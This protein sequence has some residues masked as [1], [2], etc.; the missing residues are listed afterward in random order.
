MVKCWNTLK[1]ESLIGESTM[2]NTMG[3][4]QVKITWEWLAGFYDGEGCLML[5]KSLSKGYIRYSPQ[6]DLVNTNHVVMQAIV[7]FLKEHGISVYV[8]YSKHHAKFH[9]DSTRRHKQRMQIRIARMANV[10]LF[11]TYIVPHLILKQANAV[12]LLEFVNTRATQ[13]VKTSPRDHILYNEL[14][15]LT[16]KGELI[17]PSEAITPCSSELKIESNLT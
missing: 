2:D 14:K 16:E 9:R 17:K 8:N 5:S 3:N 7:D 12:L 6:V 10:K 13:Q 1:P 11:L 4:Q 15:Q